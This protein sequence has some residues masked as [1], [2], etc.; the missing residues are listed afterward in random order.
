MTSSVELEPLQAAPNA[1]EVPPAMA[2]LQLLFGKHITYSLSA[3]ARLGVADKMGDKP[4][5]VDELA[6]RVGAHPPSLYRVMR[7]LAGVGV[8]NELEGKKFTLTHVGA[9]LRT[10]APDSLRYMAMMWG[11]RFST[12]GFENITHCLQTGENG[13]TK[14][15]GKHIFEVLAEEPEQAETFHHAMMNFSAIA[16][17]ALQDAYDFSSVKRLADVGGGHGMLLAS[18]VKNHP[19]M[20]GVLFDLPE[21]VAGAPSNPELAWLG[22]RI[23]IEPG[24]F[25]EAAPAA[26]DVY[27]LKNIIHDWSD[28]HC[29][30]ILSVIADQLT[31]DSRVLVFELVVPDE[32][33]PSP[34]KMLDI[35]M[36]TLTPGGKER[37]VSEFRDLFASAGLTL[38]RVIP[39]QT[40]LCIL[41][42]R[43]IKN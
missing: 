29:R 34:A 35:E 6:A 19:Q 26:C 39:T 28:D 24:S 32:P 12:R 33:G 23:T 4:V 8:F 5:G 21:V 30:R 7:M 37:T 10:D 31:A 16:G 1:N 41:E 36:L 11:D 27:L 17:A 9:V 2:M 3:V 38:Q 25:F 22:D 20:Q 43:R 18:V 14:A 42:A 40:P 13:V 15:Y